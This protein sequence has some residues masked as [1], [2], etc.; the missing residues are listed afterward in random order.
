M[1]KKNYIS[2]FLSSYKIVKYFFLPWGPPF[3]EDGAACCVKRTGDADGAEAV[4]EVSE[5][6]DQY[7]HV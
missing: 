1:L 2:G 3:G 7:T 5:V 6:Q 4:G